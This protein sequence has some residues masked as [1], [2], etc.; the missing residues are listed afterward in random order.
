MK[1]LLKKVLCFLAAEDGPM[2]VE[3]AMMLMLIL[4]VCL[5]V[6][7]TIGQKA[8]TNLENSSSSIN[9]SLYSE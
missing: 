8:S 5:L 9:E 2:A 1:P 7:T 4:M 6:I 3:Y